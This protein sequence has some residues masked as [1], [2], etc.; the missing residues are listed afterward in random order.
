VDECKPLGDGARAGVTD[1][2]G[3]GARDH[4]H[5]G[6]AVQV[7]PMKPTVKAPGSERLKPKCDDILSDFAFKFNLR[8]YRLAD[9]LRDL[10]DR[11]E[12]DGDDEEYDDVLDF[13]E[14]LDDEEEDLFGKEVSGIAGPGFGA[15]PTAGPRRYCSL[16]QRH[17]HIFQPL[18][19]ELHGV[20]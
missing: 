3:G 1:R 7:D 17:P 20:L 14:G 15:D 6:R 2:R 11:M 4:D 16:R 8:R 9:A 12:E 18:L 10:E 13:D 19:I 5:T